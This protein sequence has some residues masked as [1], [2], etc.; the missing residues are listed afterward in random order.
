MHAP[1]AR[2]V[3]SVLPDVGAHWLPVSAAFVVGPVEGGGDDAR[4]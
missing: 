1:D 2:L 3:L 4:L